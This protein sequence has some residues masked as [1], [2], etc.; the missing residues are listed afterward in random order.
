MFGLGGRLVWK[1][2]PIVGVLLILSG[3]SL[4]AISYQVFFHARVM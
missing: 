4:A 1:G 3:G 2:S